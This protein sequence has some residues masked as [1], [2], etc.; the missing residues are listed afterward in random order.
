MR[1]TASTLTDLPNVGPATAADLRLLGIDTPGGLRGRDPVALYLELCTRTGTRHDPCVL[2][3]FTAAVACVE[4][5]DA[6][7]WWAFTPQRK[8][9]WA[10]VEQALV[11]QGT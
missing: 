5:G 6:R 1:A 8:A 10:S 2:D 11:A 9:G 7:P 4:H 3:V